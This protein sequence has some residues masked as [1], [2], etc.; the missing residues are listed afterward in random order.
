MT[1]SGLSGYAPLE[2]PLMLLDRFRTAPRHKD[3]DPL[4]RLAYVVEVPMDDRETIAAVALED[5]D[6]RVRKAAVGKLLDP[7]LLGRIAGTDA[8]DDVRNAAAAMLRDIALDAFEE[9]GET[10]ALESV[11][12]IHDPKLVA[13]IAKS[14]GR[15]IVALRAVSRLSDV[16]FLGSVA[17]HAVVEAARR[18]AFERVRERADQ[19]EIIAVALNG[20]YKDT[21]VAAV[22]SVTDEK[23]VEHIAERGRNKAASKRA[24]TLLRD[25][26]EE[27][28][29]ES[30]EQTAIRADSL[31][32]PFDGDRVDAPG[33]TA[34]DAVA[35]PQPV[36]VDVAPGEPESMHAVA[37]LDAPAVEQQPVAATASDLAT[38][39]RLLELVEAAERVVAVPDSRDARRDL[40]V[41]RGEWRDLAT[42]LIPDAELVARLEEVERRIAAR[43]VEAREADER[44]RRDALKRVQQLLKRVEVLLTETPSSGAGK[45]GLHALERALRDVRTMTATLPAL[46]TKAD[47]DDAMTRL[48]TAH[49]SMMPLVQELREANEWQQWANVTVQEQLCARMEALTAVE[50]PERIATE[51]KALQQEWRQAANVP[52]AKADALW[53]RFKA[54]H[55]AVW[56]RC[57]AHFRAQAELRTEHLA[58]KLALCEQAEALAGS[59]NWIQAADDVKRLQAEWKTVGPV[60]R[61]QEKAVWD[62]FHAA[63]NRFFTRRHDDLVQRK[64]VWAA[65]LARKVSL[66]ERAEQLSTSTEWDAA[67][68]ELKGLQAEWRTIGPVRKTKSEAIWQRFRTASDAFFTRYSHRHDSAR[69]ERV[70]AREAL[71]AQLEGLMNDEAVEPPADLTAT[72]QSVRRDWQNELTRA[73][74]PS[75]SRAIDERFAAAMSRLLERWPSAFAGGDLD[76]NANRAQMESLVQGIE[77]LAR[78]L[79]APSAQSEQPDLSSTTKL[80]AM[81][82]EALAANTIR[83]KA[84]PRAEEDGRWRAAA[85]DVR[86]AQASWSRVGFVPADVRKPLADRF[87]R[88]ARSILQRAGSATPPMRT[89]APGRGVQGQKGGRG[90]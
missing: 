42:R 33:E 41:I 74:D 14:A 55:D 26:A 72:V 37:S 15:D 23:Q 27:R 29:R 65:N 73:I 6:P 20:E 56:P 76:V 32:S 69:M 1:C 85:E 18:A 80:A 17:R 31:E 21:A 35:D 81:L 43:E 88:A 40:R 66:C 5:E 87:D 8:S 53:K 52:L 90:R 38:R 19:A 60:V 39:A 63:C 82:K 58:R 25:A 64:T 75:T 50:D 84:D 47:A 4:V 48:K 68:A 79:L 24:R 10:E 86:R 16:K 70:A 49:A 59:S 51:V 89:N 78:K 61:S 22:E 7:A 13:Q 62:R 54:A 44:R 45:P 3:P 46:P 77:E 28:A 34:V 2:S 9:A 12:A 30:D 57:E 11:D 71:C 36:L 83:G 67:A